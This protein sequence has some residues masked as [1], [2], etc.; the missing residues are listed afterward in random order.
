MVSDRV[1]SR[2]Q[3]AP[4]AL[5]EWF[6]LIGIM[7]IGA[8]LRTYIWFHGFALDGK[9]GL[10][11][12]GDGYLTIAATFTPG[13]TVG[14]FEHWR[15]TYQFIYPLYLAPIYAFGLN[16]GVYV[17]WLHH[18]FVAGTIA[19]MYFCTRRMF[20]VGPAW[21]TALAYALQIQMAYWFNWAFADTAF[22]FHLAL[23]FFFLLRCWDAPTPRRLFG[24]TAC[25]FLILFTRP[26]GFAFTAGLAASLSY[27]LASGR[28]GAIRTVGVFA[29][30]VVCLALAGALVLSAN[31]RV[32]EVV[33]SNV[34]VGWGLY[35]GS[36]RTPTRADAVDVILNEM[37]RSGTEQ[38]L[39]DPE[40]RSLWY[41][42]SVAGLERI[43]R[44]PLHYLAYSGE[45]IV[46]AFAPSF[47]REGVSLRYKLI[48]RTFAL[49]LLVGLA[50]ALLAPHPVA[51]LI[52]SLAFASFCIFALVGLYQSEWDVRV[53]LSSH[54]FLIPIASFGWV[55]MFRTRRER[56]VAA[57]PRAVRA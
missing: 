10:V 20:G 1:I 30:V 53:Q 27:R 52:R 50:A 18:L 12:H 44:N 25:G 22:H 39:R 32:R 41:W 40:H 37:R 8:A 23:G 35:Y 47:F 33:F 21:L 31:K 28:F 55:S 48:D 6:W 4:L 57:R 56:L 17:F 16:D 15:A 54:V 43:R 5:G 2:S 14:F 7:A 42:A 19:L 13:S 24:L 26:E 9:P 49:F 29:I 34:G 38:S 46:N 11:R 51:P 3:P 45:R 36:H